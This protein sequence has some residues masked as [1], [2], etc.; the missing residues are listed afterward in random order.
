MNNHRF[1]PLPIIYTI[2]VDEWQIVANLVYPAFK[3]N[4]D[5][6]IELVAS[7]VLTF[8]GGLFPASEKDVI[9]P[10]TL[11]AF[12]Y[13]RSMPDD[14]SNVIIGGTESDFFQP[15]EF[16]D[17]YRSLEELTREMEERAGQY[18]YEQNGWITPEQDESTEDEFQPCHNALAMMGSVAIRSHPLFVGTN[19]KFRQ[20]GG[21][22]NNKQ[23]D[24]SSRSDK[25][26][27]KDEEPE[28]SSKPASESL[29]PSVS[30]QPVSLAAMVAKWRSDR[31]YQLGQGTFGE[32][33][34]S[35]MEGTK[36]EL[37]ACKVLKET[38]PE[39]IT[40]ERA[41]R[42]LRK[43]AKSLSALQHPGIVRLL[44]IKEEPATGL[45]MLVLE[46]LPYGLQQL[47]DLEEPFR[48]VPDHGFL[49]TA[50]GFLN[51]SYCLIT[52]LDYLQR[53]GYLYLDLRSENVRIS[54]TGDVKLIDFGILHS[55]NKPSVLKEA[56]NIY[57]LAPELRK[58][59]MTS[60]QSLVFGIGLLMLELLQQ[61][62]LE[63][64]VDIQMVIDNYR[65]EEE[66]RTL[67]RPLIRRWNEPEQDEYQRVLEEIVYPCC[68][69]EPAQRPS[70]INL[71]QGISD[72]V[73]ILLLLSGE[74]LEGDSD[75]FSEENP[76]G[77]SEG[78]DAAADSDKEPDSKR[79]RVEE[80]KRE[81]DE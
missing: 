75:E 32:V 77:D 69:S 1:S 78:E 25:E 57:Y 23:S 70:F 66:K 59:K 44:E 40:R 79:P 10:L 8:F 38:L 24:S 50:S 43:E 47:I 7:G 14:V 55:V 31:R 30:L 64:R 62:Y 11:L 72:A 12:V 63:N 9:G 45:V 61:E 74:E 49:N 29:Q 41:N 58:G 2:A 71:E 80:N 5:M 17:H 13:M 48:E 6:L 73:G 26:D 22:D 4:N 56:R 54:H 20:A 35:D 42:S 81:D 34:L 15:P 60:L 65:T 52:A 18:Y 51:L 21:G 36:E 28:T 67:L 19:C 3:S 27:Q 16:Y 37:V 33:F 68:Q 46:Y 53:K 39:G 76:E